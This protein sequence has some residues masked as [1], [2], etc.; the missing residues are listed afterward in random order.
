MC[1]DDRYVFT[2]YIIF[3]VANKI[4]F[5]NIFLYTSFIS[6]TQF[7]SISWVSSVAV[8]C[9]LRTGLR[10]ERGTVRAAASGISA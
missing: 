2:S 4:E 10:G 5:K 9:T 7:L 1:D 8:T 3:C 6:L